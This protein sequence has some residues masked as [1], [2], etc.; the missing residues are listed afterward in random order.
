MKRVFCIMSGLLLAATGAA[1][2]GPGDGAPVGIATGLIA[3]GNEMYGIGTVYL[4]LKGL[5]PPSTE[6]QG[7]GRGGDGGGRGREQQ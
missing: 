5:V 3:H 2:Q 1:A 4:R 6:D 7:S